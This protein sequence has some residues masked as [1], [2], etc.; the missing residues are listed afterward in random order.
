MRFRQGIGW[1]WA[2]PV[3]ALL[4]GLLFATSA[5]TSHGVD[6]R[7]IGHDDGVSFAQRQQRLVIDQTKQLADLQQ[8]VQ[9]ATS[10]AARTDRRVAL[11]RDQAEAVADDAGMSPVTG[12]AVTVAL[13]DA[14]PLPGAQRGSVPPDYLVVHQQ[15]VQAVVNAL[16]AGGAEAMTL[17]GQ[18]VIS[19]SAVRCVGNTLLLHGVVYSP[20]YV[21]TA[22]GDV[23]RLRAALAE[24]PDI[25]I[26]K[27]YVQAYHLG[28][29]VKTQATVTMPAYTGGVSLAYASALESPSASGSSASESSPV[30]PTRSFAPPSSAPARPTGSGP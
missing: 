4:A 14:P 28:Y 9:A 1:R 15:D 20:P 3:A 22:I 27:Q 16:W 12:P 6:I 24:A 21:V 7:V 18:R 29:S 5:N 26:Y 30:A 19:T 11:A 10:L 8:Q 23:D 25:I 13:D 2:V 17:Q